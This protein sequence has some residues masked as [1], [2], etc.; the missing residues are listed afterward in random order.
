MA[1][2]GPL[3]RAAKCG[4]AT[5]SLEAPLR[6]ELLS[7]SLRLLAGCWLEDAHSFC[8]VNSYVIQSIRMVSHLREGLVPLLRGF[9]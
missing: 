6:K 7:S 4:W 2:L 1:E 3:L 9:A 8:H 5:F